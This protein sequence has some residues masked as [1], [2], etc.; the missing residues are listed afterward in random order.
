MAGGSSKPG[1]TGGSRPA[2]ISKTAYQIVKGSA[3]TGNLNDFDPSTKSHTS[4]SHD[5]NG[6]SNNNNTHSVTFAAGT[7]SGSN[8][9]DQTRLDAQREKFLEDEIMGDSHH[10]GG[11]HQKSDTMQKNLDQ[12]VKV[13][14]SRLTGLREAAR[15]RLKLCEEDLDPKSTKMSKQAP[16]IVDEFDEVAPKPTRDVK[17][18]SSSTNVT[19]SNNTSNATTGKCT[20]FF[21]LML[22]DLTCCAFL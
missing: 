1:S 22:I 9:L 19:T 7:S 4:H 10:S 17:Y 16:K 3:S 14:N 6:N 2:G 5:S 12:M 21:T 11:N 20:A 13:L 8:F 15:V 18:T